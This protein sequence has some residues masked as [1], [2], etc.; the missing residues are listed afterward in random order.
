VRI[1]S[2]TSRVAA[3][4]LL[5]GVVMLAMASGLIYG[6]RRDGPVP[7]GVWIVAALLAPL[8]LLFAVSSVRQ[9]LQRARFGAW[10]L[11]CPEGGG[12]LGLPLVVTLMPPR[13]VAPSTGVECSLVCF[14]S[15]G[16]SRS[17][18]SGTGRATGKMFDHAWTV[19]AGTMHPD[20]GLPITVD[21]PAFGFP[22]TRGRQGT[23]EW[24]LSVTA[25]AEGRTHR[26]AFELPVQAEAA[27][28]GGD[29]AESI[30]ERVERLARAREYRRTLDAGR[31]PRLSR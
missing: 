3:L 15:S 26:M 10:T 8:G 20:V 19:D 5:A 24:K 14:H 17:T 11:E 9:L 2:Q 25:S 1:E 29:A 21:L 27:P 18:H 13:V 7:A 6:F 16:V 28:G 31:P 4:L 23:V 12:R 22:S 30:D